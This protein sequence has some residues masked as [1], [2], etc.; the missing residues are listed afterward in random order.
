MV[1]FASCEAGSESLISTLYCSPDI[2]RVL[3][4]LNPRT[5]L[6]IK[7]SYRSCVFT[8]VSA[9]RLR[10][11]AVAL[12]RYVTSIGL[13]VCAAGPTTAHR[14]TARSIPTLRGKQEEF[15]NDTQKYAGA[16]PLGELR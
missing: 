2:C 13:V 12:A 5:P 9:L 4:R 16:F 3:F 10:V 6:Q 14:F 11:T 1:S 15:E 8:E 7:S